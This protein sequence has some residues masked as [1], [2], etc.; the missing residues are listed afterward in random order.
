MALT[1][2][3]TAMFD[4][5]AQ[6][7]DLNIDANTLFVDVSTNRVGIGT[8][9]PSVPLEV[10]G[11][12]KAGGILYPTSDGSN[13]QALV[14]D[15]SGTASFA[16]VAPTAGT[17]VT[18]SGTTVSIGQAVA[19]SSNVTFNNLV[20]SGTLT[21]NGATNTNSATNTTIEDILIELGTGTS[22]SPANDA[23]LVLERGS[24]DNVFIGWDESADTFTVGTGSFTGASS[25]NLTITPATAVFGGLTVD[26]S[27]LVVDA[28]NNRVGIG[29]A[30]P[31]VSLD[32]GS[33][34]DAVHVPVGTTAQRPTGAA[35]Y[36]RYNSTLNKFEGYT[37]SWG[38]IGGGGS[39]TFTTD[40]FT[41]DGVEDDFTLSQS[42]DS[43]NNLIVFIDGVYQVPTT[44][45]TVSGTTL[46]MTAA[47]AN[48]R[49]IVAYSVQS[50]ISGTNLNQNSFTGN[51]SAVAFTLSIAPVNENNTQVFL[52][53]V[54][55]HKSTYATSGTTLTFD[56]A[57]ASGVAIE[58]MIFTQTEI[59]V[60]VDG[61]ITTTKLA[62]DAV[63]QAKIADDAVGADQLASNAVVTASIVNDAVTADK[64]ADNIALP[65]N[66][67]TTGTLAPTGVLTA[68]AG[69]KVDN[70]TID[71]Q[72]IDISSGNFSLDV[73]N[74]I[75]LDAGGNNFNFAI[76]GT[77][78][79]MFSGSGDGFSIKS[80]VADGDLIFQGNDS[81]GGGT[82][83]AMTIDMSEGGRVGIGTTTP[84]FDFEVNRASAAATALISSGNND[85]MLRLYTANNV[86]KWRIIARTN[87]DLSI[88]N[89][90]SGAT[91]FNNRLTI[92]D[93]G[94]V[95]I[96]TNG[97]T[98]KLHIKDN[99]QI[100][101]ENTSTTGW[102]GLDIHTSVGTN[103]YDMYMG[104]LD[105]DGRFFIDVNSNG[106]DLT[107]LQNG[108]VGIATTAPARAL[109]INGGSYNQ[110]MIASN[111]SSNTNKL[112]GIES[113]NYSNYALGLMQM[114][115]NSSQT[116]LYHGSADSS[117]KGVTDH[118]FMI[119]PSVDS[120]TNNIAMRINSS[121]NVEI[122]D[123]DIYMASGHGINFG[124]TS[125][126]PRLAGLGTETLNDYEDGTW[127]P[128][129]IAGTTNPTGGGALAPS[130]RYTKIGN[131]V[132]VTFYV[133]RSWT[134]SPSG[135]IYVSGLPYNINASTNGYYFPCVTYNIAFQTGTAGATPFLIPDTSNG[136]GQT[137]ALY[138]FTSG[139]AWSGMTWQTNASS[140]AGIYISGAFSYQV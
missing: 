89:L 126:A 114:F 94:N 113:R 69:V 85:A 96:G 88:E 15:G 19:T 50:A 137:L 64:I 82:I 110:L 47:P 8:T 87:D 58:V 83:T 52:D 65:G 30:S 107:I 17:G 118:Y 92:M 79:G 108:N 127:T 12:L 18:V 125:N 53:G 60:P 55:Q 103:D 130:G 132:W 6:S 4:T 24:S 46:T 102:A 73:A 5:A 36:F 105:S 27:T 76:N 84:S 44:A 67:T 39:N 98:R 91:A 134:N 131:R 38:E 112:A 48:T 78:K 93:S 109:E 7:S 119:S 2:V 66:I 61:T 56:T 22:G 10:S 136:L 90:N 62:A 16:T 21:V 116:G 70:I 13:G 122:T 20:V 72:G 111:A 80:T 59:N 42:V 33:F 95:G 14:T 37:T 74:D 99:G 54:Y 117:A 34:T 100:K 128:T 29:N 45:Y 138:T 139:G 101:L 77:T 26:T 121:K 120:S 63:T 23:G 97:P 71:G 86:G 49:K 32:V 41:G 40:V 35:G 31:D 57:P 68:D 3:S 1:K 9:S 104:M 106:E 124:A 135:I 123:G 140:S 43:V 133:G 115:A 75:T 129:L 81:D 11:Q 28:S 25:G 51:G